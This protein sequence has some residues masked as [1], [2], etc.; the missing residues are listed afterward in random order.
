MRTI[1]CGLAAAMLTA[2]PGSAAPADFEACDGYPAPGKRSDGFSFFKDRLGLATGHLDSRRDQDRLGSG[3]LAACDSALA[4]PA[5]EPRY[6]L[7]RAHLWQAKGLHLLALGRDEEALA[8]LS[9]SDE[10]APAGET[11]AAESIGLGS[12]ALRAMA[13]YRLGRIPQARSEL[14]SIEQTRPYAASLRTLARTVRLGFEDAD[15]YFAVLRDEARLEPRLIA[16]LFRSALLYGRLEEAAAVYGQIGH[17][18][19]RQ[20]SGELIEGLKERRYGQIAEQADLAGAMSYVLTA[21]GK[22]EAAAALI[23]QARAE[24]GEAMERPV[25]GRSGT[26]GAKA[27]ADFD[28]RHGAG[29]KGIASLEQWQQAIALRAAAPA[30][31]WKA[32]SE[33]LPAT[34]PW[35]APVA[36]DLVRQGRAATDEERLGRGEAIAALIR[37]MDTRRRA[38]MLDYGALA[39]MLPRPDSAKTRPKQLGAGNGLLLDFSSGFT[40]SHPKEGEALTLRYTSAKASPAMVEEIGMLGAATK[41]LRL[42]KD[43]FI[44]QSRMLLRQSV[45]DSLSKP[46]YEFPQ[47]YELWL[48]FLPVGRAALPPELEDG[49]W[50]LI[51]AAEV[52]RQLNPK[53]DSPA[54]AAH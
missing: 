16:I 33:T 48:R 15:T 36:I 38:A 28:R 19:P 54:A 43:S 22:T 47:G 8:A 32:L 45:T 21:Q 2:A 9:R 1:L 11:E 44:V 26:V 30:I 12:R 6:W 17:E 52:Y 40:F 31:G 3:A 46:R 41:T 34:L 4:D 29:L 13:L 5:L 35:D 39:Q 37:E 53:Y 51:D 10:S 42:G 25:P 7:R 24:L 49:R 27:Q 23:A 18:L 50:R 14:Q 20:R